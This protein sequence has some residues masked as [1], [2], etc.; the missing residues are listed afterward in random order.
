MESIIQNSIRKYLIHGPRSNKKLE[1]LH[2]YIG[3]SIIGNLSKEY[4]YN[5]LPGKEINVTGKFYNKK[6]D[7]CIKNNNDIKGIVSVK[8]V[9]SNFCQN[10]NNYFENLIGEM[11]NLKDIGARM[12]VMIIFEDTPYYNKKGEII[13][14]EKFKN[15]DRYDSLLCDGILSDYIIIK[16]SNG[17]SLLHPSKIGHDIDCSRFNIISEYPQSYEKCMEQFSMKLKSKI[18]I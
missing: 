16:I 7:I 11:Y 15:I 1:I 10:S 8:F 3:K 9:M 12:H 17:K 6:V 2:D 14:Y 13:R 18:S 4:S 5:S